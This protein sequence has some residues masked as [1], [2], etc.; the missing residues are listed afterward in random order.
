MKIAIITNTLYEEIIPLAKYLANYVDVDLF[1]VVSGSRSGKQIFFE[2]DSMW[3]KEETGI[4]RN[5]DKKGYINEV[6]RFYIDGKFQNYALYFKNLAFVKPRNLLISYKIASV[7]KKKNYN[8]IH[9]NG[10]SLL[11]YFL[12]LFIRKIPFVLTTHDPVPHSGEENRTNKFIRKLLNRQK[13]IQHIV[14]SAASKNDFMKNF[15]KI[16]PEKINVIY[17]GTHEWLNYWKR[18]VV[19][20][21]NNILFFGRI[22]Q[23][24]GVEYLIEAAKIARRTIPYLKVTIAGS[25]KYYFDIEPIKNDNTFEIINR[26]IPNQELVSLMQKTSLVVCPYTDATQSGVIMTAYIFDK[27][28]IASAVGGIPDIVENNVTGKLVPAKN[29]QALA[30]AIIELIGNNNKL[31]KMSENIE[32]IYNSGRFSWEYIAKQ[33]IRV[34]EKSISEF[35]L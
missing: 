1:S 34:Y 8:L 17:Y 27:P 26:Y 7:L 2:S 23:Y 33:T 19:T 11:F 3:E 9:F 16:L 14:H 6:F 30:N 18:P 21:K 15:P 28:V 32:R 5:I 22:S 35:R 10:T 24:K 31:A 4:I 13:T 12:K 20:D 25:G 29:S